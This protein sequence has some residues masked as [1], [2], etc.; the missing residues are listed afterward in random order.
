M[1]G[2]CDVA[3]KEGWSAA[4]VCSIQIQDW[5]V[6]KVRVAGACDVIEKSA[7]VAE[8]RCSGVVQISRDK[9][10]GDGQSRTWRK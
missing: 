9:S 1:A 8:K 10:V 6:R 7:G 5:G 3:M 2:G 4:S